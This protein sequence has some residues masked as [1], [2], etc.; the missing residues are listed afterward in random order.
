MVKLLTLIALVAATPALA[1]YHGYYRQHSYR[2]GI[3]CSTV[4]Y[5]VAAY[6]RET[7]RQYARAYYGMTA[8]QERAAESCLAQR[9]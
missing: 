5:Y 7:A 8:S 3:S 9:D 4:R 2:T 1:S 6:G